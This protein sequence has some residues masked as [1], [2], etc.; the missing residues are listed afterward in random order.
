MVFEP[1]DTVETRG[2]VTFYILVLY[3][4]KIWFWVLR[5]TGVWIPVRP[6]CCT[7]SRQKASS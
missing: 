4:S 1:G 3:L 7:S 2:S 6:I 5:Q